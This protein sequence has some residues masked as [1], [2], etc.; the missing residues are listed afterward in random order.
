MSELSP[1]DDDTE[2][3][4][5]PYEKRNTTKHIEKAKR[6]TTLPT[7]MTIRCRLVC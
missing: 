1:T 7:L 2:G 5:C 6:N 4:R 3:S